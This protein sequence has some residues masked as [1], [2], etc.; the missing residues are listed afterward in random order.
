MPI[1]VLPCEDIPSDLI[2]CMLRSDWLP[3]FVERDRGRAEIFN[4]YQREGDGH[5]DQCVISAPNGSTPVGDPSQ[6][7]SRLLTV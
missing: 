7:V 4:C 3:K 1:H 5:K 2:D 6:G